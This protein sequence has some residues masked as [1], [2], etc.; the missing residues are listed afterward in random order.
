MCGANLSGNVGPEGKLLDVML[1][2]LL[3]Q[4][5]CDFKYCQSLLSS[6]SSA[7]ML[8]TAKEV[9]TT[10]SG[11]LH[12]EAW[13]FR[14]DVKTCSVWH[15]VVFVTFDYW[16]VARWLFIQIK[17]NDFLRVD[18]N[19]WDLGQMFFYFFSHKNVSLKLTNT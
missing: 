2:E 6:H 19:P 17:S 12:S 5:L 4:Q 16:E 9:G 1:N 18:T 8:Q 3:S 10:C 11:I 15:K 14:C 7:Y 13:M